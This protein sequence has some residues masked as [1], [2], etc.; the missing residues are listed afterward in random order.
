MPRI[1]VRTNPAERFWRQVDKDGPVCERLGTRCWV[2]KSGISKKTG[3]GKFGLPDGRRTIGAHRFAWMLSNGEPPLGMCVLHK[4]DNRPCCNPEHLFLGSKK[5]NAQ[6]CVAKGR[7]PN[8]RGERNNM[9]KLKETDVRVILS[10][11]SVA[12]IREVA[13]KFGVSDRLVG[14][15]WSKQRWG[16]LS[17]TPAITD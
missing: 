1:Y 3:Y 4:C 5:D 17:E 11:K 15:I 12:S 9:A 10:L 13:R 2:W 16:Y 8:L 7:W 6:D 14:M